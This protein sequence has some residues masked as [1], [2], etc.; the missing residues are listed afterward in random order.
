MRRYVLGCRALSRLERD[1]AVEL[2]A[3]RYPEIVID[4]RYAAHDEGL[5]VWVCQ[6]PS[7][8]HLRRWAAAAKFTVDLLQA[9]DPD[10]RPQKTHQG[11][12]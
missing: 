1:D 8:N 9:V 12:A 6:A 4:H 5:D 7:E 3:V 11:G 2:A 10:A